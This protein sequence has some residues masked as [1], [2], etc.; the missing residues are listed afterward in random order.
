MVLHIAPARSAGAGASAA[1]P[2]SG[3]AEAAHSPALYQLCWQGE[4]GESQLKLYLLLAGASWKIKLYPHVYR[5]NRTI[6]FLASFPSFQL[7]RK[8]NL[9]L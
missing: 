2:R 5:S 4:L 1:S 3:W 9:S 8:I 7:A 6:Y